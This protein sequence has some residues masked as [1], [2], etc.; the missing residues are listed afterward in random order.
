MRKLFL[1]LMFVAAVFLQLSCKEQSK[2]TVSIGC[3][4]GDMP[5]GIKTKVI[6]T[7]PVLFP[8]DNVVELGNEI[9]EVVSLERAW[10]RN[11]DTGALRLVSGIGS[12]SGITGS[13]VVD[14]KRV[15]IVPPAGVA[16]GKWS[17]HL[18]FT[19]NPPVAVGV[20]E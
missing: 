14:K 3:V 10:Y 9:G 4:F 5:V 18:E 11:V 6:D 13:V 2:Q 15:Y 8:F 1:A 20:S 7:E 12:D 16:N 17:L 19:F